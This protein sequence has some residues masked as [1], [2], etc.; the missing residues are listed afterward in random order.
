MNRILSAF[1]RLNSFQ[2]VVLGFACVIV[3]GTILLMLPVSSA[4]G[5]RTPLIDAL[6]TAVTSVCVTSFVVRDTGTYW[7]T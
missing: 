5:V 2:I 4:A 7:S 6:F 1:R 3:L